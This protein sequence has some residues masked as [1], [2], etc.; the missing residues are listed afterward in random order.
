MFYKNDILRK[1][2]NVCLIL[3]RYAFIYCCVA[4]SATVVVLAQTS[5][6]RS[7]IVIFELTKPV[8]ERANF[9]WLVAGERVDSVYP[10]RREH[11]ARQVMW[12]PLFQL[13]LET[14]QLDPWLAAEITPN[15]THTEW[16][17]KL[18]GDVTWSDA[19]PKAPTKPSENEPARYKFDANDVVFTANIILEDPDLSAFE[20]TRFRAQVK[21]VSV[22]DATTVTFKL[23]KSNPR[24]ALE[25]FGGTAFGSLMIMPA[26]IW[27]TWKT[28]NKDKSWKEFAFDKP[29]GTGPYTLREYTKEKVSYVRDNGW[30]AAKVGMKV[31]NGSDAKL[32]EPLELV[33][34]RVRSE[35]ESLQLLKDNNLDAAREYT[36]DA[37]KDAVSNNSNVVGWTENS[38]PAWNSACTRQLDINTQPEI[39]TDNATLAK[40][41]NPWS[42]SILR[43]A[44][45][46]MID[47]Q[48][49]ADAYGGTTIPSNTM[50]VEYGSMAPF[51]EAVKNK[52]YGL[53]PVA[54]IA[55][56]E[57]LLVT[58]GYKKR[59]DS[60]SKN[61]GAPLTIKLA[62]NESVPT[63]V[64][65]AKALKQQLDSAGITVRLDLQTNEQYWGWTIPNGN[66]QVAYGWLSC[67]S[68]AEPY[69]SMRRYTND[70]SL[71]DDDRRFDNTGRWGGTSAAVAYKEIV[72][73]IA[74][75][76][77][78][79]PADQTK[80]NPKLIERMLAAYRHLN[81]EMPFI[82]LVQT[83]RII[84]FNTTYW[85]G[86]PT[87][88]EP[89]DPA[90]D[91]GSLHLML[92][93]LKRANP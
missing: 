92:Q 42:D 84:P 4:F 16:T 6:L 55:N 93:N 10:A 21:S 11:G 45:S 25:N 20:A 9:N 1:C 28:A 18:R 8:E 67:G 7:D 75:L 43:R 58:A 51:I 32:P 52:G 29:I 26:H 47:R 66:Y 40:E 74:L 87:E 81:D 27:Q 65:G 5:T 61:G 22:V 17:L 91:W 53:S 56:A 63:D 3:S 31:S 54:D 73:E 62:V 41:S 64:E 46:L 90:H 49:V 80:P 15:A 30:W 71:P 59:A 12:E 89:G 39:V 85:T 13:D 33:W 82:P 23:R 72:E 69:T 68:I 24:F 14:G 86:W 44:L 83:P 60:V 37:F 88:S 19:D 79:D 77:L 38:K 48:K 36:L 2:A 35:A 34:Q 57:Q 78:R 50:F 76:P 70:T